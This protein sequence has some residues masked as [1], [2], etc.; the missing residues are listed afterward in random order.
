MCVCVCV[1]VCVRARACVC[2][3]VCV[4]ARLCVYQ[5]KSLKYSNEGVKSR[6]SSNKFIGKTHFPL[7][8]KELTCLFKQT[9]SNRIAVIM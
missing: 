8:L 6:F 9:T 4:Y 5:G 2:V 3:C 1:C 7:I